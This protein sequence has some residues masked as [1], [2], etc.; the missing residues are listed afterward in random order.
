[1]IITYRSEIETYEM[2]YSKE[3]IY[4]I[5]NLLRSKY[6]FASKK[7]VSR[8]C[9]FSC[10]SLVFLNFHVVALFFTS[11]CIS[12]RDIILYLVILFLHF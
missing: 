7:F 12:S 3:R 10:F 11:S 4:L 6:L 2:I 1:M 5:H 9:I 8:K